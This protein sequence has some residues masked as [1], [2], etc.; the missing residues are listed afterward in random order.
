MPNKNEERILVMDG[1]LVYGFQG[2]D[3]EVSKDDS[4]KETGRFLLAHGV[5]SEEKDFIWFHECIK[6]SFFMPRGSVENDPNF[7][8]LI[9]YI[10]VRSGELIFAYQRD[11]NE[12]RLTGQYSIGIGGHTNVEDFSFSGFDG[13]LQNCA[14]RELQEELCFGDNAW[15]YT[16]DLKI[17]ASLGAPRAL[18]YAGNTSSV[19]DQVH[20]GIIYIVDLTSD[21]IQDI[22]LREEGKTLDWMTKEDL[23]KVY[24]KL[25]AWSQ[26]VLDKCL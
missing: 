13:I 24:D 5:S 10:I 4:T 14:R 2:F 11:G 17:R 9:P 6:R 16:T 22:E 26:L 20:F 18:L 8:Q 1:N 19:V 23:Y 12:N 21:E 3:F 15:S 7:K 25:E